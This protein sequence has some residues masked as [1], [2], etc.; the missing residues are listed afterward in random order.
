MCCCKI[1]SC[2][3]DSPTMPHLRLYL[4]SYRITATA[5]FDHTQ[6][7]DIKGKCW[8]A[9][10]F[11]GCGSRFNSAGK[12]NDTARREESS[13][14]ALLL[15][16]FLA[17]VLKTLRASCLTLLIRN[18]FKKQSLKA[19]VLGCLKKEEESVWSMKKFI[20]G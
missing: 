8:E 7:L 15:R 19:G 11:Y 5:Q 6:Y 3:Q 12:G 20:K 1:F 16:H 9:I 17:C 13:S 14:S 2:S 10:G 18:E 4:F